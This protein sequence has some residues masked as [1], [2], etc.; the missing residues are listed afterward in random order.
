MLAARREQDNASK[1]NMGKRS[2]EYLSQEEILAW[3][4]GLNGTSISQSG[5]KLGVDPATVHR[6][7]KKVGEF[8]AQKFDINEYRIPLYAL[9]PLWLNSVLHNLK[10][11]DVAL[12]V[13]FGKGMQLFQ[14]KTA[15][16]AQIGAMSDAD[17][18]GLI[19]N[20][21]GHSPADKGVDSEGG[22]GASEATDSGE[23]P[24]L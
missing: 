10:K 15:V 22:L 11:N 14:E 21:V 17:L 5:Q 18:A 16:D 13:A 7:R 19:A 3:A 8:I 24:L 4:D 12:T 20:A 1:C 6:W 23:E 9:Y 2:K